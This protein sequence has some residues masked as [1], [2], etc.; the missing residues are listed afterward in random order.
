[1]HI[2]ESGASVTTKGGKAMEAVP[3]MQQAR[4]TQWR[5]DGS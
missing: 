2:S 1:M 4:P 5:Q 3:A